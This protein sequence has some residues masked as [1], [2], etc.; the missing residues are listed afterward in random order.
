MGLR[1]LIVVSLGWIC[2]SRASISR[3]HLVKD[4]W[5]W[6]VSFGRICR[7]TGAS[8]LPAGKL[9]TLH[10]WAPGNCPA[11]QHVSDPSLA[12]SSDLAPTPARAK[13]GCAFLKCHKTTA[14]MHQ[15]AVLVQHVA[16]SWAQNTDEW[17]E[18]LN[19]TTSRLTR[20]PTWWGRHLMKALL[21]W[22]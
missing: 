18:F 1:L 5:I 17:I 14:L 12:T 7:I 16:H 21:A 22:L 11:E 15:Q 19:C 8:I 2:T 3:G 10:C 9:A 4:M 6:V 20:R 13:V